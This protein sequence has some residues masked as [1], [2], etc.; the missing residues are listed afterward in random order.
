MNLKFQSCSSFPNGLLFL[1]CELFLRVIDHTGILWKSV[2]HA[3][4]LEKM[5]AEEV[6][7]GCFQ[8]V[9]VLLLGINYVIVAM[10]HALPVFHN[11]TPK[12][13]CQVSFL[14][15]KILKRMVHK[16]RVTDFTQILHVVGVHRIQ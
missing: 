3:K 2:D 10:S 14:I 15:C 13:Y 11:Y 1:N 4:L 12:Y 16:A 5:N 7:V 8:V 9:I 6:K